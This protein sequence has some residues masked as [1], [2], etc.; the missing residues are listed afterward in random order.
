MW[1]HVDHFSGLLQNIMQVARLT[2]QLN[3]GKQ[4]HPQTPQV[5]TNAKPAHATWNNCSVRILKHLL[6]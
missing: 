4:Q 3:Q 5:R 2:M 1:A 6:L